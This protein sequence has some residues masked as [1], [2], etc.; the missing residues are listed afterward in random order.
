VLVSKDREKRD[1]M[2]RELIKSLEKIHRMMSPSAVGHLVSS[3][4]ANAA[5]VEEVKE[6]RWVKGL[7]KIKT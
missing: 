3:W 1:E 6:R 7:V 2:M 5:D 4:I